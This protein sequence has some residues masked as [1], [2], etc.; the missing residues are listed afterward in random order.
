[1]TTNA[2]DPEGY[3][4]RFTFPDKPPLEQAKMIEDMISVMETFAKV[5]GEEP[6]DMSEMKAKAAEL[7]NS[8]K[9]TTE[10]GGSK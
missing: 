5:A 3:G 2:T 1:M 4:V 6:P 8:V 10:H 9:D 7:R